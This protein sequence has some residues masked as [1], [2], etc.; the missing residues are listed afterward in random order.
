MPGVSL[1]GRSLRLT[2]ADG[3]TIAAEFTDGTVAWSATGALDEAGAEDPYDAV[4]IREGVY[5]LNLPLES[6]EREALTI[7]WSE[8]TGRAIVTRSRIDSEKVAGE[9][10][11]KQDFTAATVDGAEPNGEVPAESRDLIGMRNIYRYSPEHLY[12]H[13][14]MSTER[15]AWQNLQGVQR[16][17]GDMDLSTVWKLDDGLYLFCFREFRI[18]VASV[19]L[20]DLGY[21]LMTTGIFLG[22]NGAGESE[23]SRA[24]GH[25]YPLGVVRYPD[26]QPV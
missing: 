15:Y 5:F 24:G 25:I 19:W 2:L 1:A 22:I 12:E 7:V 9:P 13:V 20:H 8:R 11:V 17:H 16:G 26:A 14:Y 4:Q 6:R 3:G 23:H 21:N 10:Q 18:S